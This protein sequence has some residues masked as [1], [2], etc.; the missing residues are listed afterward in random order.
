MVII[1]SR[2][3][4]EQSGLMSILVEIP[5]VYPSQDSEMVLLELVGLHWEVGFHILLR[6]WAGRAI[7]SPILRF[8]NNHSHSSNS[9]SDILDCP[10]IRGTGKC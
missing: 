7:M 2:S 4:E 9:S 5:W 1:S 8:V 3:D 10:C 6:E